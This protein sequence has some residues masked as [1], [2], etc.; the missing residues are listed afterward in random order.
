MG[1]MSI[2][3]LPRRCV[4]WRSQAGDES[5][6]EVSRH[7]PAAPADARRA[8]HA[9]H[10]GARFE[11]C[12]LR[13]ALSAFR[14]RRRA[15]PPRGRPRPIASSRRPASRRA[16]P[17]RACPSC[18][19]ARRARRHVRRP[20]STRRGESAAR[21]RRRRRPRP[22][23]RTPCRRRRARPPLPATRPGTRRS[24]PASPIL[25]KPGPGLRIG[26]RVTLDG[27]LV[28]RPHP[29]PPSAAAP[30]PRRRGSRADGPV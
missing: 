4:R 1:L 22:P 9:G 18:Q 10:V 5:P 8:A 2:R 7:A 20:L 3:S 23:R 12:R 28:R 16:A 30:P 21:R 27:G 14:R 11:R 17:A 15:G 6:H 29:A 24:S 26:A 19:S 25:T 13:S